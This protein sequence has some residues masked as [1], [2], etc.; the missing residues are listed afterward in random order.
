LS[1]EGFGADTP[2]H[3]DSLEA[4]ALGEIEAGHFDRAKALLEQARKLYGDAPANRMRV[5][6]ADSELAGIALLEGQPALARALLPGAIADLRTRAYKMP[7]LIAEARLLLACTQS[8]GPQCPAGLQ[9][10][11]EQ[12][13]AAVSGRGDPML[14]WVQ[15]LLAR[16]ELL[17]HQPGPARIRLAQAIQRASG[18]LQPSHPRRVA[19]RLWLALA[20]A[21]A[22]DCTGA[23]AQ[24][25][26]A[27]AI[28]AANGLASHPELASPRAGLDHPVGACGVLMR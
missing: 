13:L 16:V 11:V 14:L 9:A 28:I 21:Q 22:G 7:P 24:V 17:Q 27:R 2:L 3:G 8:P 15:T 6:R 20:T 18:E 26:A 25:Q 5:G 4:T 23:G 12:D 19:A 10:I 1:A